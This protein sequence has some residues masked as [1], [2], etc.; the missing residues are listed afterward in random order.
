MLF[1]SGQEREGAAAVAS[2]V[3]AERLQPSLRHTAAAAR[4]DT[5]TTLPLTPAPP[6]LPLPLLLLAAG[7][8][9]QIAAERAGA[10]IAR[11]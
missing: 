5:Y 7:N 3:A 6:S 2:T 11:G 10:G 8:R 4:A 1:G 9:W